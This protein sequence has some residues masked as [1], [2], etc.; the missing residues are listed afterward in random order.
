VHACKTKRERDFLEILWHVLMLLWIL[1][2]LTMC[3][4]AILC[5]WISRIWVNCHTSIHTLNKCS[6]L[7]INDSFFST[8]DLPK[9]ITYVLSP[10]RNI[11]YF[12][13]CETDVSRC[14]LICKFTSTHLIFWNG[15][16]NI[17][18]WELLPPFQIIKRF[19]SLPKHL[20]IWNKGCNK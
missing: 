12:S 15:G 2:C 9:L 8:N 10:L 1:Y 17:L 14:V 13:F 4:W 20:T 16:S 3:V 5:S 6:T 18:S 19:G 7:L 11:R